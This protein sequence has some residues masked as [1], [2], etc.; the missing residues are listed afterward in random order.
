MIPPEGQFR[1]AQAGQGRLVWQ[2]YNCQACH[3]LYGLGGYLGPDLSNVMSAPGKGE[4]LVRAFL[5]SP[6]SP[7]PAFQLS[8]E[9]TEQLMAFLR[10][11]DASGSAAPKDFIILPSGMIKNNKTR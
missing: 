8:E 9:E 3:Q 2:R 11:T 10:E 4:P 1:S 5:K 7:M 6:P